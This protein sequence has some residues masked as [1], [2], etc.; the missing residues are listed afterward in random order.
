MRYSVSYTTSTSQKGTLMD[1]TQAQA[2][3]GKLLLEIL[4][5]QP[6]LMTAATEVNIASGHRV[7][8]FCSDFI[9]Q[10]SENLLKPKNQ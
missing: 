7:A 2:L 6:N 4:R 8:N 5:T 10:Y 1:K 3:A 9:E